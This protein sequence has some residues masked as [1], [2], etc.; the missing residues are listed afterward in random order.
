MGVP[1]SG[2]RPAPVQPCLLAPYGAGGVLKLDRFAFPG[3]AGM[4][5]VGGRS[6]RQSFDLLMATAP[7][8]RTVPA[9]HESLRQVL[10]PGDGGRDDGSQWSSRAYVAGTTKT[11]GHTKERTAN[12]PGSQHGRGQAERSIASVVVPHIWPLRTGTVRGPVVPSRSAWSS[13][14]RHLITSP[15]DWSIP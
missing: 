13:R 12:R 6:G 7:G 11:T 5:F 2:P 3:K 10:T 4:A 15:G 9:I 8:R 14:K 1:P